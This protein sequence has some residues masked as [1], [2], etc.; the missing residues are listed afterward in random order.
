[1]TR[2][3]TLLDGGEFTYFLIEQ[4]QCYLHPAEV[5]PPELPSR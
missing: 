5:N 3:M 4:A 1:M 2:T